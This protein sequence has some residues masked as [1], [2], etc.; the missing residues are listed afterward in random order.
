MHLTGMFPSTQS[1]YTRLSQKLFVL[2]TSLFLTPLTLCRNVASLAIFYRYFHTNCLT[3]PLYLQT[4]CLSTHSDFLLTL[5]LILSNHIVQELTSFFT[6]FYLLL[7][8]TGTLYLNLY[9]YF[10]TTLTNFREEYQDTC[11]HN[12]ASLFNYYFILREPA[13]TS[14]HFLKRFSLAWFSNSIE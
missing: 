9:F 5:I 6:L 13:I 10:P 8:N 2:L 14:G 11:K 1:C 3:A 12:L 4:T 7:V